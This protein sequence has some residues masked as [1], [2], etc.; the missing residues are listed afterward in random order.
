MTLLED[1]IP[2]RLSWTDGSLETRYISISVE[3]RGRSD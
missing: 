3:K 1:Y 2:R